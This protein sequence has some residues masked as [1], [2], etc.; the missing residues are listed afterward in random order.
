MNNQ[1]RLVV[2]SGPSGS[3]KDTVVKR[4]MQLHPQ[5]ELSISATTRGMRP[6]EKDGVD[7]VYLTREEFERRIAHQ[8]ILEYAEYCGNYYGTPKSEV[9]KRIENG[10]TVILVIEVVGA[11]NVKRIY[12]GATTIF[13][14]PPSY[15]ELEQRLRGRGTENEEQ[16][17]S[18]LRRAVEEMEYAV[19]YD[20]VVV[21]NTVDECAEEI[22]ELILKH[23]QE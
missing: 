23:Q 6:G 2:V 7:Y 18:R 8:E 10:I 20:E 14:R 11:A 21:N 12:P 16:I 5:V 17:Q 4:L 15:E 1:S 13:V 9:D 19:D 3:G 22:Y